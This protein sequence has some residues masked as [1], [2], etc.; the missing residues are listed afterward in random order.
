[1]AFPSQ[2]DDSL[3]ATLRAAGCIFAEEEA[4]ILR[5]HAR[6]DGELARMLERRCAGEP[7]EYIVERAE[8]H[9]LRI[10]VTPGVFIPRRRTEFLAD[11]AIS[12][13]PDD[14]AVVDM[15]C[16]AG[17]IGAAVAAAKP[18]AHIYA[19]DIDPRATACARRNLAHAAASVYVGDLF[20]PL[21]AVLRGR[22]DVVV[23]NVPYV[24]HGEI[25]LLPAEARDYEP[26]TTLDGGP[27]GLRVAA[28]VVDAARGW[29]HPDGH[30]LFEV[31][32]QQAETAA[33]ILGSTGFR[34]RI[35]DDYE[36]G[37]TVAIGSR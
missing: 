12:L 18:G 3:V 35:V 31:S 17:A 1:M 37:A 9:G 16:G 11:Q 2:S 19:V 8:F 23:A 32:D 20:T 21:P 5:A 14:A 29:L 27:D 4:T 22:V 33:A 34:A 25:E 13:T 30:I 10:E 26:I 28:R 36:L 15:C 6:S 7:L 24:P